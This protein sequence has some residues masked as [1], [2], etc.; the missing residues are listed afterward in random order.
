MENNQNMP[1]AQGQ[2]GATQMPAQPPVSQPMAPQPVVE[3]KSHTMMIILMALIV[4]ILIGAV[5]YYMM[6]AQPYSNAPVTPTTKTT[7]EPAA[8]SLESE[9]E[10]I[11]V[12]DIEGDFT[13]VDKDLQSL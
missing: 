4:V 3:K 13:D 9:V 11:I 8:A 1:P 12:G 2:Q 10:D 5:V 6:S 7:G